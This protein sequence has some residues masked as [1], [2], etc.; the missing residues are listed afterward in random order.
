MAQGGFGMRSFTK[1]NSVKGTK[2]KKGTTK[3]VL[4]YAAPYKWL[5]ALFLFL[6]MLNA[7]IGALTPLILKTIIDTGI[8]NGDIPYIVN[9]S[10]L[11]GG[12]AIASAF[13]TLGERWLSSKIGEG[14]IFDLQTQLFQHIQKMSLSF[15]S[16]T[17]TGA[18]VQRIN[19]DVTGAQAVFTQTLSSIFS[20]TL[21][22]T[23]V[24][25]AMFSMSWQLT[26]VALLLVPAF[27]ILAR[28][29]GPKLA[30]LM[31]ESY[32]LKA[33][34][35][36]LSNERFN[37][38]G[39]QL[40][41]TYGTPESDAQQYSEQIRKVRDLSI[42]QTLTGSL[43]RV[44][45]G[46]VSALSV[47]VV[48]GLGGVLAVR[49][50]LTVGIVVA[51]A[52]Y[53]NRL[54]A[55]ITSLSNVQVDVLTAMVSF[56]RVFEILDLEP[57]VKELPNAQPLTDYV[58]Q[59]GGSVTFDQVDFRYP[60]VKEV[61]LASLELMPGAE[62]ESEEPILKNV[63]FTIQ[64]GH[65]TALVGPSGAG[66]S[67]LSQLL[68][69][70]YDPQQG[71]IRIGEFPLKNATLDSVRQTIGVVSQDAHMFHD[72]IANNLRYAKPDATPSEIEEALKEAYIWELI[73]S[74]PEGIDTVIGDRG[75]RLS[76]GERQRLAIARL[77]LKAPAIV[78][79]DEATAHLDSESEHYIQEALKTALAGRTSLVIAHRLST[80]READ[81]I[82]VL[83]KGRILQTGTHE[84]LIQE[85]GLYRELYHLQFE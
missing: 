82:L 8:T 78:I 66:K 68:T 53:L 31:R 19:G 41:K 40:A 63:S 12:L 72:T 44:T 56:E 83:E 79:L 33:E 62:R 47:A 22:V 17:K 15:F 29:V 1:D 10:L 35:N 30:K 49:G 7:A 58:K 20:N 16:R 42:K 6:I 51:L 28:I 67:T 43:M 71:E 3:R 39:A 23:F 38:A 18:L 4:T 74:L 13:L 27:I 52:S 77:L 60:T 21:S 69:R 70:M 54:Y 2:L 50:T 57:S 32:D 9:F 64:P 55:P 25:I 11:A 61:S 46:T 26:L 65:M 75:Y 84:K 80:V 85:S 48:Y 36:Q 76:G 45:I 81:Q 14:V 59:N 34:A 5:L 73:S 37:V 24:L